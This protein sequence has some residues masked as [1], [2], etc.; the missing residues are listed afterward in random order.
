MDATPAA[1]R[2]LRERFPGYL[3]AFAAG[4][5]AGGLVGVVIGLVTSARIIDAV[6]YTYSALGA[7]LLLVG[8]AQGS[9]YPSPGARVPEVLGGPGG[10]L[11]GDPAEGRRVAAA[12]FDPVERR[13]RRL[14]ARPNPAAL[15]QVVA[16]CAYLGVGVVLTV[17]FAAAAG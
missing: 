13:R 12:R 10:T 16:G 5:G 2:P 6:G 8:G 15:W 7:L 17:L 3:A 11:G 1:A 9:G 14:R 4:L